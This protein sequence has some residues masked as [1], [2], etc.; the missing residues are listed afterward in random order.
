ME[1]LPGVHRVGGIHGNCYLVLRDGLILIDTG[2]PGSSGKILSYV[3]ETLALEP[4]AIH[5]IL[6]THFHIDH[7][8]NVAQ[9]RKLTKAK[10]AIHELDAAYL[11][12]EKPMPVPESRRS[13]LARILRIFFGFTPVHADILL[14]DGDIAAGFT[15]IHTPGHTPG[16]SCFHD[17]VERVIFVGDA[18]LTAGGGIHGPSEEFSADLLEG[19]RSL[20]KIARLDFD[21]L[22]CGHGEPI[23]T[24]ASERLR[25]FLEKEKGSMS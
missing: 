5:T 17:P 23:R 8:G 2:M 19:R 14:K 1:I 11:S 16:S 7:T 24:G 15:C 9:L 21:T 22:L 25:E 3:R 12:G 6:L 13:F 18:I 10:V 4:S 20:E